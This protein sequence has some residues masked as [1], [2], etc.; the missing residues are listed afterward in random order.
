[1]YKWVGEKRQLISLNHY[2]IIIDLQLAPTCPCL[3][4]SSLLHQVQAYFK[5]STCSFV[6][7][8][9]YCAF[10]QSQYWWDS[11]CLGTYC[12]YLWFLRCGILHEFAGPKGY[13]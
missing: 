7:N 2:Q 4:K 11:S 1:M 6:Q 10:Y 9:T 3:C 13:L 8:G 5:I 12:N